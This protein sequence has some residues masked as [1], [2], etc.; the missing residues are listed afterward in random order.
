MV[1]TYLFRRRGVFPFLRRYFP[2]YTQSQ[3]ICPTSATK[4]G[5]QLVWRAHL[6]D[7][8][9]ISPGY[10]DKPVELG[11]FLFLRTR[12]KE[13]LQT[14]LDKRSDSVKFDS[15]VTKSFDSKTIMKVDQELD[16]GFRS[17]NELFSIMKTLGHLDFPVSFAANA[18]YAME[19]NGIRDQDAYENILFPILKKKA[20]YLHSDGLAGSIWALGQYHCNDGQL[21]ERIL[22]TYNEKNFGTDVVY[23]D[24]A[25]YTNETFLPADKSFGLE[26]YSTNEFS[27]MFYKNHI[28]CLDLCEGL[29]SLSNQG[30]ESSANQRVVEVL[31][32]LESRQQITSDSY[33]FYKQISGRSHTPVTA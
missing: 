13:M 25:P 28:S 1:P 26:Y 2:F 6:S 5:K 14:R 20:Q 3:T 24:N 19:K 7:T 12:E 33:W 15:F 27:K 31:K 4:G 18:L 10:T 9:K 32:D 11:N 23:V 8:L 17:L 21:I 22:E 29:K 30:L 16:R